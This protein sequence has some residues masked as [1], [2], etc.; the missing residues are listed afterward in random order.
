MPHVLRRD[1]DLLRR[2]NFVL[3]DLDH[4]G[5]GIFC[6]GCGDE[7]LPEI[8]R[9]DS[10]AAGSGGDHVFFS[11]RL[12]FCRG[13]THDGFQRYLLPEGECELRDRPRRPGARK[14]DQPH[15][16]AAPG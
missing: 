5:T 6:R 7:V 3:G 8:P 12:Y 11:H 9:Q 1:R 16:G 14:Q 15:P 4:T 10:G 2:G 13:G